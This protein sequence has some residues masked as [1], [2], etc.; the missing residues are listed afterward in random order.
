VV[1]VLEQVDVRTA[2]RG[3]RM[4]PPRWGRVV[5]AL[6]LVVSSVAVAL[7]VYTRVGD[8]R[9]VLVSARTVLAGEEVS[10]ADFR[11]VSLSSD[12]SAL[13]T[14]PAVSLDAVSGRYAKVRIEAGAVLTAGLL[15]DAP[16]VS[17]DRVLMSVMVPLGE[18]PVG[19]RE[20]S[21]V[22]LVVTGKD[23][24]TVL[25]EAVVA[26][27]PA[28]LTSLRDASGSGSETVALSV[29]V[30]PEF[31]TLVGVAD[32]VSVGVLDPAAPLPGPQATV[33]AGGS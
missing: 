16:L 32:S 24:Q 19:L 6:L 2:G 22:V 18:V 21:R 10:P 15:Q 31:V 8:R 25:V 4:R 28:S 30:A 14:V 9:Q 20:Q 23:G 5:M 7:A 11:V 33:A 13:A 27:V 12:D 1:D 3:L 17:A 29:E 26:A